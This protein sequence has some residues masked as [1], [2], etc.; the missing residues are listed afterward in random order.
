[1]ENTLQTRVWKLLK[2]EKYRKK[3]RNNNV[4]DEGKVWVLCQK[5]IESNVENFRQKHELLET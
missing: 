4:S 2:S 3:L 1:M 5:F